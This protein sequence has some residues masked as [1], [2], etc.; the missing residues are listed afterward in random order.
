MGASSPARVRGVVVLVALLCGCG[1]REVAPRAERTG[2]ARMDWTVHADAA[3][4]YRVSFPLAW[5]RAAE[6]MSRI[7][8]PREL[9]SVGTVPLSWRQTECEAFAGAAGASMGA[10]DV[11][12]TVWERGYDSA[13]EWSD[14]PPRP[15]RSGPVADAEPAGPGCAE[16]PGTMIHWRNFSDTGRHF[17][18]LVRVGPEAPPGAAV[19]AWQILDSLRFE[20]EYQPDEAV[21]WQTAGAI[22]QITRLSASKETRP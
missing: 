13:S 12:L 9:L 11:V 16:P 5:Y 21:P 17:H 6:R 19:E 20:A 4:G 18:S 14:F 15:A 7:S 1:D 22:R 8:D 10:G 3:R 2:V